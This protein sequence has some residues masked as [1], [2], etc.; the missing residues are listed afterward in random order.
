MSINVAIYNIYSG[1]AFTMRAQ[2]KFILKDVDSY[3]LK[4]YMYLECINKSALQ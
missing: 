3:C 4:V 2:K 1:I